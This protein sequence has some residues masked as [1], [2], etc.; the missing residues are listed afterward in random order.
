MNAL[1]DHTKVSKVARNAAHST[2]LLGV[3]FTIQYRL[4]QCVRYKPAILL[5]NIS[6]SHGV[7]TVALLNDT[8]TM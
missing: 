7:G 2:S 4:V 3:A 1:L 6:V 8:I 5:N